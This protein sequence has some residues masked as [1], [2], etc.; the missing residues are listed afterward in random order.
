MVV[1]LFLRYMVHSGGMPAARE[2]LYCVSEAAVC[3]RIF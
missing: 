1:A 3:L 2:V